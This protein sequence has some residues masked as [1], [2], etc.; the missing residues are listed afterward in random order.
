MSDTTDERERSIIRRQ[1]DPGETTP[2]T[3]V[4]ETIAELKDTDQQKLSPLYSTV[5]HLLEHMFDNPPAPEAQVQITVTYE[6][7]RITLS[8]DGTAEFV[9]VT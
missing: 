7:Y 5:D 8:Q 6:G 4:V 9:K 2:E 3:A 1:F